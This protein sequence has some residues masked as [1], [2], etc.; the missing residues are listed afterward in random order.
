MKL[1][2]ASVILFFNI[3][4]A[5]PEWVNK[6]PSGYLNDYFVGK[7]SSSGSK[8]EASQKAFEDA[9]VSIIRNSSIQVKYSQDDK[10][11]STQTSK[12]DEV[13]YEEVRKS[14]QELQITGES[15]TIKGLKEVETYYESKN[16]NYVAWVLVN[17][18]KRNPLL[19][20]PR[21]SPVWRSILLPGWGQL[22]KDETFKGLSFMTLIIGGIAGGFVLS[23]LSKSSTDN[24]NSS[25]TQ[26]RRDFFNNEAKNYN[27]YS[28]VSFIVAGV[29]Y[30][31]SLIDA[32]AVK[33]DNLY[34]YI[35][36]NGSETQ[37]AFNFRL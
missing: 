6:T 19:P 20:P 29:F 4:Y 12:G 3:I 1:I 10:V 2:A 15:K 33:Q 25:R 11:L 5:Q 14:A 30:S 28:I 7:G 26:V 22:Y 17:L 36:Q 27:T 37:L 16:N 23:E 32:I 21:F 34:I 31:W 13:N 35:Q 24:A 18:P 8:T 9:I